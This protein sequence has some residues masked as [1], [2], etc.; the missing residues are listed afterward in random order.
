[1]LK[2]SF[3]DLCTAICDQAANLGDLVQSQRT[4]PGSR[5]FVDTIA[6]T[7]SCRQEL[8]YSPFGESAWLLREHYPSQ[9][10]VA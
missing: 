10:T 8:E 3:H 2:P 5:T 9:N 7:V 1:M 6:Q 4:S